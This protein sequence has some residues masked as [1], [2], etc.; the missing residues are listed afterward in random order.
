MLCGVS[1]L[2]LTEKEY[3]SRCCLTLS[4]QL[5]CL[6]SPFPLV[7]MFRLHMGLHDGH[8]GVCETVGPTGQVHLVV[9]ANMVVE[10]LI[11]H[12]PEGTQG[13]EVC[14]HLA[15][16][17]LQL[18]PAQGITRMQITQAHHPCAPK[19]VW[20]RV[21]YIKGV[22]ALAYKYYPVDGHLCIIQCL[23]PLH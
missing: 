12:G 7:A 2:K 3:L 11:V 22:W 1:A 10:G 9:F 6:S 17:K 23:R 4:L 19:A 14:I 13:A 21:C 20:I 5:L 16:F 8:T 18:C 15:T